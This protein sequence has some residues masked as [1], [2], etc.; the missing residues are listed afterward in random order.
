M[1]DDVQNAQGGSER[2]MVAKQGH[3]VNNW[4]LKLINAINPKGAIKSKTISA[5][6]ANFGREFY[7]A[8]VHHQDFS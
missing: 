7:E 2:K 1:L 3:A 5:S 6:D 4:N 8:L